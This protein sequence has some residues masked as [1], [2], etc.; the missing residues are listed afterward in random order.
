MKKKFIL[1]LIT[2]MI[3]LALTACGTSNQPSS[4]NNSPA[5]SNNSSDN[6][7]T[8]KDSYAVGEKAKYKDL[9]MTVVKVDKSNG[10][11]YDKPTDG[12]EFVIA[13]VKIK[14][15]G[16]KNLSYNPFYFKMKNSSGQIEDGTFST[17][18]QNT[19]LQSGELAKGGEVEGTVIFQ[20]K[21]G[22]N[23]LILQYQDNMFAEGVKLQFKI[24]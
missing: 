17:V 20:E 13:T 3:I 9:E 6:K 1:P 16:D 8:V 24:S 15:N 5:S 10:S 4:N 7:D 23:G 21:V 18:N 11:E 22:D 19:A 14:N 2:I 12:K